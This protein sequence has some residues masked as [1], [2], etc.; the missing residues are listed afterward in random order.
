MD[1]ADPRSGF[2]REESEERYPQEDRVDLGWGKL[3]EKKE[4]APKKEQRKD[5]KGED[6]GGKRE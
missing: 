2:C 3:G 4:G 1:E 6:N 5:D